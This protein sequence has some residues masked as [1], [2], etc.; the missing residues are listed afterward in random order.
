MTHTTDGDPGKT[1]AVQS[2]ADEKDI[3]KLVEKY[4]VESAFRKFIKGTPWG[5][6][7][8]AVAIGL[9]VFQLYAATLGAL[10][11]IKL[12]AIH[13]G[14][15]MVLIFLMYPGS[16]RASRDR[17]T[18]FDVLL[19]LASTLVGL[20]IVMRY[21]SF[22]ISGG[23]ANNVDYIFGVFTMVL[24]L[25]AGR[26]SI[27][28]ILPVMA[29]I[30]LS[31]AYFGNFIPGSFGHPG[32]TL[33]RIIEQMYLS[34]D[35]IYG[36]AIGVSATYIFLFILF[37]AFLGE[38]G[39]AKFINNISM[40][41]AGRSPGGP[42]KVSI[43]ASG[44]MGTING[45]AVAN[46]ATTGAFTIPLMKSVGYRPH[47]AG[48]V[49]AVASTG[50]QI[51]PPVMGAA[52]FIM[53]E[54]LNVEYKVVMFAALIPAVLYYL[55]CYVGV[56]M[57]ALKT[58]L[59]GL[60]RDEL[61]NARV[62]MLERGH[63]VLPLIVIVYML[64]AGYTPTFSAVGGIA[65]TVVVS[66]LR[67]STRMTW[68]GLIAALDAGARGSVGVAI[69][70]GV[71]GFIVGVTSLT[72][73]GIKLGDNV[74]GLA[75]GNLMLT[76][77]LSA[78]TCIILGMGMPTTAVYIV[79]ATM[80]APALVKIGINPVAA[81]LF[82]FY[83]GNISNITPPVALAAFTGAGIAGA[84]PN[85]VGFTAV[86]L[87]IAAFIVPFMFVYSPE[88]IMQQG[89]ALD[90]LLAAVTAIIGVIGLG[91]AGAR[92]LI[93]STTRLE[94]L[95]LLVGAVTLIKPGLVTDIVGISC[96]IIVYV[97]QRSRKKAVQYEPGAS[98]EKSDV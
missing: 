26:R 40:A 49:E 9:S 46:V 63:L 25:E 71:V 74:I 30:F 22:A 75:G 90:I 52:A 53:A 37:G 28:P 39:M 35:G 81:H 97:L 94:Q 73:F 23:L 27:G 50:G 61:P 45:S 38:T 21:D 83:F 1:T 86:R 36:V 78:I 87:G 8:S 89:S 55:A 88:L 56:H 48:A 65:A 15:I 60:S 77:V 58:G 47:F 34:T 64:V 13:L 6:A 79:A 54:I 72:S 31:Y 95:L 98:L 29:I 18:V 66:M 14:M 2:M 92:Y 85:Q 19:A 82:C 91:A 3:D 93:T 11:A 33:T 12:R 16:S 43:F 68:R 80:A 17:P 44:L 24:V 4:D 84:N 20:Y 96:L 69:A 41:L 70:C 10:P 59:K 57:E 7:V 51:M 67:K 5:I 76:L 42:A 62:V 32:F